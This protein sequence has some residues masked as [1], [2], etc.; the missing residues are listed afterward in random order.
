[1][2]RLLLFALFVLLTACAAPQDE[3]G[4]HIAAL[5]VWEQGERG[6][7]ADVQIDYH[8]S[9]TVMD[10]LDNGVPLV[11]KLQLEIED[12]AQSWRRPF[13]PIELEFRVRYRPLSTV[14]EVQT[15]RDQQLIDQQRFVTRNALFASLSQLRELPLLQAGQLSGDKRYQIAARIELALDDLPLPIRPQAY[16]SREWNQHSGWSKWP[17]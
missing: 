12:M 10:A 7:F 3:R 2:K 15:V 6:Y 13:D 11:F 5:S 17:L 1:M 8:L 4:L 9:A 14:Y 16:L